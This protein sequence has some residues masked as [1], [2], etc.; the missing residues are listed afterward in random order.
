MAL[1][2]RCTGKFHDKI[3][4][5]SMEKGVI[6]DACKGLYIKIG[7]DPLKGM[8][9]GFID[10]GMDWQKVGQYQVKVQAPATAGADGVVKVLCRAS[11]VEIT[12]GPAVL[13]GDKGPFQVH[14]NWSLLDA[15]IL[16]PM[17]TYRLRDLF[18]SSGRQLRRKDT[19]ELNL[20][21]A[22]QGVEIAKSLAGS[23]RAKLIKTPFT[24]KKARTGSSLGSPSPFKAAL[25][26]SK[27]T[28]KR[29]R[30]RSPP[31]SPPA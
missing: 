18:P 12:M 16:S 4:D 27:C 19:E 26:A 31:P 15:Y 5:A 10:G 28:P 11:K 2:I 25:S 20:I 3:G 9:E 30:E 24:G 1:G 17:D 23:T 7:A 8:D 13:Q 22:V 6:F 14:N 21:A 29:V